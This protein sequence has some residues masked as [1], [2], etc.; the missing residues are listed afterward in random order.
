MAETEAQ[1]RKRLANEKAAEQR[2]RQAEADSRA[3]AAEADARAKQAEAEARA[4]EARARAEAES[5]RIEAEREARRLAAEADKRRLDAEAEEKRRR[6]EAAP[7]EALAKLGLNTGAALVGVVSGSKIARKLTEQHVAGVLAANSQLKQLGTA[8]ARAM[9]RTGTPSKL[10]AAKLSAIVKAADDLKLAKRPRALGLAIA[11][12]LL[13]E[14]LGTRL[15][16]APLAPEGAGRE[17][18]NAVGTASLFAGSGIVAK[19]LMSNATTTNLPP[20]TALAQIEA[21]RNVAGPAAPTATSRLAKAVDLLKGSKGRFATG[22]AVL[23]AA[24]VLLMPDKSA[25]A[26]TPGTPPAEPM[27]PTAADK[28]LTVGNVALSTIG[29]VQAARVIASPMARATAG[30]LTKAFVPL[31]V[32]LAVYDGMKGYEKDGIKGAATGVADSL[33]GGLVSL[34]AEKLAPKAPAPPSNVVGD[35]LAVAQGA[36]QRT[37]QE[38][39]IASTAGSLRVAGAEFSDGLTDAYTRVQNGK[40]VRVAAYKTPGR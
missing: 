26:A 37:A 23:T 34:V 16:L 14:G 11:G 18:L 28:A 40:S 7:R 33:S 25:Q 38:M 8:A 32:G 27:A 10:Q 2:T 19:R 13:A 12:T 29:T 31:T 24:G 35:R 15:F 30:L 20:A 5:A 22:A 21:A 4:A 39:A 6:D 9:P 17:V 3:R 1:R 36:A